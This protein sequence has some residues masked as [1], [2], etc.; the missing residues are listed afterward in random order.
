[1]PGIQRLNLPTDRFDRQLYTCLLRQQKLL[2]GFEDAIHERSSDS[3]CHDLNSGD[4]PVPKYTNSREIS[5][6]TRVAFRNRLL[7]GVGG[8]YFPAAELDFMTKEDV[9]Q[10]FC[11]KDCQ[12]RWISQTRNRTIRAFP[13]ENNRKWKCPF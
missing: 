13:W 1:M 5:G 8:D 12:P 4:S 11:W 10:D 2:I 6:R 9:H 7:C 3:S